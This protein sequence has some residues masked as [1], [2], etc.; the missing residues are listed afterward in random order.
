M[1]SKIKKRFIQYTEENDDFGSKKRL[2]K[3]SRHNYKVALV[4]A[5]ENED[6]DNIDN[7]SE[8][9]IHNR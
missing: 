5:I 6:W 8:N 4:A 1:G 9:S 2:K 7:D 3:E